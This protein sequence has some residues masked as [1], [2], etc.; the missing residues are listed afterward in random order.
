MSKGISRAPP[1]APSAQDEP[2]HDGH[3]AGPDD[4]APDL[5]LA[6]EDLHGDRRAGLR[7]DRRPPRHCS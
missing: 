2:D 1:R 6:A 7:V 4:R 5:D 3:D